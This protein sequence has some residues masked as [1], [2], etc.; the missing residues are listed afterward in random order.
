MSLP[1]VMRGERVLVRLV[2]AAGLW[3]EGDLH[4]SFVPGIGPFLMRHLATGSVG[5]AAA[6]AA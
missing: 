1:P 6:A 4:F 2:M 5:T 3:D